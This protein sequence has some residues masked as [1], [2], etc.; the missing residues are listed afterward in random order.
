MSELMAAVAVGK[1]VIKYT[2]RGVKYLVADYTSYLA[3]LSD[4]PFNFSGAGCGILDFSNNVI[5]IQSVGHDQV[6][7]M[8]HKF[9]AS[10]KLWNGASIIHDAWQGKKYDDGRTEASLLHDV[11]WSY[12]TF[13]AAANH[14]TV[15]EV[16]EWANNLLA[17]TWRAYAKAKGRDGAWVDFETYAAKNICGSS[18]SRFWSWVMRTFTLIT[19]IFS[20]TLAGCEK[21]T[22]VPDWQLDNTDEVHYQIGDNPNGNQ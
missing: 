17:I 4:K 7:I 14:M 6:K 10:S 19:I 1:E 5:E 22:D 20:L 16:K 8:I 2:K 12:A 15:D 3:L 18:V 9:P 11:I 13:I 21:W